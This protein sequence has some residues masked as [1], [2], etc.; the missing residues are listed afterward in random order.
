M[1]WTR[2]A[3]TVLIGGTVVSTTDWLVT[4]VLFHDKYKAYP[5][6]WR[7]A[8]QG[9][10]ESRAIAWTI[11]LVFLTCAVFTYVCRHFDIHGFSRIVQLAVY[12]WLAV[13]VPMAVAEGLFLKLHPMVVVSHLLSWGVKLI[14]LS[15]AISLIGDTARAS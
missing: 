1:N 9:F 14:L 4:G 15:L 5:E 3:L 8:E 6:V 11:L 12:M 2:F 7:T 10:S 13:T